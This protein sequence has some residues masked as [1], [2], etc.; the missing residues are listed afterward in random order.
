[1]W[2]DSLHSYI[3]LVDLGF[4]NVIVSHRLGECDRYL[5]DLNPRLAVGS[6]GVTEAPSP[7]SKA[8]KLAQAASSSHK[9]TS[10]F[11]RI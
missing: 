4:P 9:V 10:S 2:R 3:I 7:A 8:G 5:Q 1:M 6:G 11:L